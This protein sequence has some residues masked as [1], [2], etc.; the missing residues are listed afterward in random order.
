MSSCRF[1]ERLTLLSRSAIALL[2][3]I[4]SLAI[5][6]GLAAPAFATPREITLKQAQR[7]LGHVVQR[8]AAQTARDPITWDSENQVEVHYPGYTAQ[9]FLEPLVRRQLVNADAET[10]CEKRAR[11]EVGKYRDHY[12]RARKCWGLLRISYINPSGHPVGSGHDEYCANF[13]YFWR[14]SGRTRRQ[15]TGPAIC[16]G[17]PSTTTTYDGTVKP[18]PSNLFVPVLPRN[19]PPQRSTGDL[20]VDVPK[21]GIPYRIPPSAAKTAYGAQF[22]GEWLGWYGPYDLRSSYG[23]WEL[24]SVTDFRFYTGSYYYDHY[25]TY[26][27][28]GAHWHPWYSNSSQPASGFA[29]VNTT[30]F[31]GL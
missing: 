17:G 14:R 24:I 8:S 27:G 28:P 29:G 15:D 10:G 11:T 16:S 9:A 19:T 7:A 23:V 18:L 25:Y 20:A 4:V 26:G 12:V 31:G 1:A 2:G 6:L 13:W 30:V 21:P 3:V 22:Y 5:T